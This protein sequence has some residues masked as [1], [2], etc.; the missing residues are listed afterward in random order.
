MEFK[1]DEKQVGLNELNEITETLDDMNAG[2]GF[3]TWHSL[4]SST[5]SQTIGNNGYVCTWTT[6]CIEKC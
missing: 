6:E 4:W 1:F 5:I 3:N 2:A